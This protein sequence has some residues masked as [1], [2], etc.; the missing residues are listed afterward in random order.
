MY[1]YKLLLLQMGLLLLAT[2]YGQV[3]VLMPGDSLNKEELA[4]LETT[5]N[6]S[7][8]CFNNKAKLFILDF[9]SVN[10]KSCIAAFPKMDSLQKEFKDEIQIVLIN[11]ETKDSTERFFK[12]RKKIKIPALPFVTGDTVFNGIFRHVG[13]PY[14]VWIDGNGKVLLKSYSHVTNLNNVSN[15]LSKEILPEKRRSQALY[16]KSLFEE[17]WQDQVPYFSY[18]SRC[19]DNGM[20]RLEPEK[21]QAMIVVAGCRSISELFEI[22]FN[23]RMQEYYGYNRA[24]RIVLEV[25]DVQRY[26]Y[27]QGMTDY[28]EWVAENGYNYHLQLPET[29]EKE[30]Y[31]RMREDLQVYFGVEAKVEKRW[32][33]CFVLEKKENKAILKTK[34]GEPRENLVL[35]DS[36]LTMTDSMRYF[37][38]KPFEG[39]SRQLGWLL[40]KKWGKPFID[41]SQI[42]FNADIVLS[43]HAV[44]SL[45]IEALNKELKKYGVKITEKKVLMNVLVVKERE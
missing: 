25:N 1:R 22:A 17:D 43:Q 16:V 11:R 7:N 44:E 9:W 40:E 28:Y 15:Y 29:K 4:Y 6:E 13:E 41:S 2:T 32:T 8:Y 36:Y 14:H 26:K 35:S 37:I 21:R 30:K 38:N 5:V 23:E 10:C 42:L 12:K 3:R 33:K 39:F 27:E 20:V 45:I 34:G 18:L 24:G 31:K 19:I